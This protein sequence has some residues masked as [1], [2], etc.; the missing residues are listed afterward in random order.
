MIESRLH[1]AIL[2][3]TLLVPACEAPEGVVSESGEMPADPARE[4]FTAEMLA[5]KAREV[6]H[7]TQ[8]RLTGE[9]V[10]RHGGALDADLV[11][12]SAALQSFPATSCGWHVVKDQTVPFRY[13]YIN[14]FNVN[15]GV[16][17]TIQALG[18]G[19]A[20]PYL[21][22]YIKGKLPAITVV[23]ASDDAPGMGLNSKVVWTNP[24]STSQ[25][26]T[27]VVF[28]KNDAT[29]GSATITTATATSRSSVTGT[30]GGTVRYSDNVALPP[31]V[32]GAIQNHRFK[33]YGANGGWVENVGVLK[34][35][36]IGNITKSGLA[37]AQTFKTATSMEV[38]TDAY[39]PGDMTLFNLV[40]SPNPPASGTIR[41]TEEVDY[42]GPTNS[43]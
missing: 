23:G 30:V 31:G 18:T 19:T 35:P 17:L 43:K 29:R 27:Y 37:I 6:D 13:T 22:A 12:A 3:A 21:L 20:D 38:P 4:Q 36:F 1:L 24:A 40:F 34:N 16:T 9:V 28:A 11:P 41:L 32:C 8:E 2:I 10:V 5:V 25:V 42:T 39:S 26:V 14:S 33:T 7:A 15:P